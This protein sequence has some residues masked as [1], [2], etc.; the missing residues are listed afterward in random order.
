MK[1]LGH[2]M[3]LNIILEILKNKNLMDKWTQKKFEWVKFWIEN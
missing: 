2:N 1:E 3:I